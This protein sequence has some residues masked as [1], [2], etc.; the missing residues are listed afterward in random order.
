[1]NNHTKGNVGILFALIKGMA[2]AVIKTTRHPVLFV[3]DDELVRKQL[4]RLFHYN[5]KIELLTAESALKA[6]EIMESTDIHILVTDQRMPEYSGTDLLSYARRRHPTALR[7]L[8][9]GHA[10]LDVLTDSINNGNL[11]RYYSKPVNPE[12]FVKEMT[13]LLKV[14]E[15]RMEHRKYRFI[16]SSKTKDLQTA[17]TQLNSSLKEKTLHFNDTRSTLRAM[18]VIGKTLCEEKDSG[19]LFRLV[20][21]TCRNITYAD[22]G[23]IYFVEN[24]ASGQRLRMKYSY[25]HSRNIPY[26]DRVIPIDA[27]S[28]AG[29][30]AL[31]Q[32]IVSI[33]D[34]YALAGDTPYT[35]NKSFDASLDYRTKS[36]VAIP[37]KSGTGMALG[38]IQLINRKIGTY[39]EGG[40]ELVLQTHEDFAEKVIPFSP[41]QIGFLEAVAGQAAIAIENMDMVLQLS[42]QFEGFV[43]ASIKAIEARDPS[44]AGHSVRVASLCV[45][46]ANEIDGITPDEIKTLEYAALLHD[47]GK[48]Y[49][50]PSILTKSRKLMPTDYSRIQQ[51]LDYMY[52][53]QEL[54]YSRHEIRLQDLA[55]RT[56][57]D[58]SLVIQ[59]LHREK[60]RVL[61]KIRE[62]KR[63]I[64][65]LNVPGANN[66]VDQNTLES[67]LKE[68]NTMKCLDIDDLQ[69]H[70]LQTGDIACLSLRNGTLTDRERA[71]ME[72]HVSYTDRIVC[73]IPWPEH[74]K[75]VPSICRFHHEKLDGSGYPQGITGEAIPLLARILMV[76]DIYDA[77]TASDR[78]YREPASAVDALAILQK[79][80]DSGRIDSSITNVLRK[81]LKNQVAAGSR[82]SLKREQVW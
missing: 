63:S 10:D 53:F 73:E 23:T 18:E 1:M 56:G 69:L 21:G 50:E 46:I 44:T 68:L 3:D 33:P 78:S 34:A 76:V 40:A 48:V 35:F 42:S 79:D 81:I 75:S 54:S 14:Y 60:D 17:N 9:T 66:P 52:R 45:A 30:V 36:M 70:P 31:N 25:T 80:A 51:T 29:F 82:P 77:L 62:F 59:D 32:E 20:L 15:A 38:V 72:M 55:A 24:D 37:I 49:V 39:E 57:N 61:E 16:L 28:I 5:T 41:D 22:A 13:E 4:I 65:S 11:Y 6:R 26:V 43:V 74:L 2:Q 7:V 12:K 19:K 47:I 67:L 58:Q 64:E 27:T 8:L 71:A